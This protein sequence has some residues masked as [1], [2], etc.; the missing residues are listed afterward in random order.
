MRMADDD[1]NDRMVAIES[2]YNTV[3]EI[4]TEKQIKQR[5]DRRPFVGARD[6][7]C[8]KWLAKQNSV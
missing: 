6:A 5:Y 2:K 7:Q 1:V 4:V 3:E 8:R